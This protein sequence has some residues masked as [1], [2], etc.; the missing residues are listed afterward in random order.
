M[1]HKRT[2]R[3]ITF[4]SIEKLVEIDAEDR[5][6]QGLLTRFNIETIDQVKQRHILIA[7]NQQHSKNLGILIAEYS[8]ESTIKIT[9]I[10]VK[11]M[12][13]RLS[14]G[15]ALIQR[16]ECDCRA[17]G[18]T[19][20]T[21]TF[22]HQNHAMNALTKSQQGWSKGEQLNG[23]TFTSRSAMEPVLQKLEQTMDCRKQQ[24]EIKPLSECVQ[25]DLLQTSNAKH[26]PEWAQ[27][28]HFNLNQANEEFS[29]IFVKDN[30]IVGWLITFPLANETLDYRILWID[31]DHRK[32]GVAIKAL[33]EV[34][35]H[36]HF[37]ESTAMKASGDNNEPGI[38]WMKGFCLMHADNDAMTN[39]TAKRLAQGASQRSKL[40][41]REKRI[42]GSK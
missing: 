4:F 13:R 5:T 42:S 3:A 17:K 8:Q 15:H 36:A 7:R 12:W 27:V 35:R 28:N 1:N 26:V 31:S 2:K 23:Y 37:Q 6:I 24:T 34:I 32:T 16:L 11:T 19:T 10:H 30:Q 40:I 22:D 41:Y 25:Q 29:R 33:A 21:A 14:I 39:F 20:I 18:I 9:Y 38:P